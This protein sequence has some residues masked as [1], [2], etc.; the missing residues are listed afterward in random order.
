MGT[1]AAHLQRLGRLLTCSSSD[2]QTWPSAPWRSAQQSASWRPWWKATSAPTTGHL[3]HECDLSL[4]ERQKQTL[5]L[6]RPTQNDGGRRILFCD[7]SLPPGGWIR[8][9]FW[10]F[11]CL[12]LVHS[13]VE[14]MA[15]FNCKVSCFVVTAALRAQQK[16]NLWLTELQS[17]RN[18]KGSV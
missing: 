4:Q 16:I 18:L 9:L 14:G 6:F 8:S 1:K 10:S 17:A 7:C 11:F 12:F 13:V 3:S 2:V 5:L 15:N